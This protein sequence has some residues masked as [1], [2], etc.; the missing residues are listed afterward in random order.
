MFLSKQ[1]KGGIVYL[2]LIESSYDRET[3]TRRKKIVKSFGQYEVFAKEHPDE[4]KQL[5]EEYGSQ[6][7]KAQQVREKSISDFFHTG[8]QGASLAADIKCLVPQKIAHLLLRKIWD[9]ELLMSR[10]LRYLKTKDSNPVEFNVSN[11]ALY[12]S[13]L[14]LVNP[15]SY[16]RGLELSPRFLGDPM[17]DVSSDD[18]YRCLSYLSSHKEQLLK[19]I[20]TRLDALTKRKHSLIFYD[21]TNCYFETPYNDSYWYRKK[22]LR[23]IRRQ[24]RKLEKRYVAMSDRELNQVIENTPDYSM[25]VDELLE[26]MGEPFRMH[27]VSKEKRTDLPL[28][29]IALVIDENAIPIDFEVY[30]GNKS[31]KNTMVASIKALKEKYQIDNAVVVADNGLNSAA[32]LLM[33]NDENLGF[34]VAKSALSFEKKIREQELDL[35]TFKNM[36]TDEGEVTSYRYKIIDFKTRKAEFTDRNNQVQ[37]KSLDC[38][39]LITF[40]E[41][42]KERDLTNL[43]AMLV[44]A[45]DAVM[46]NKEITH[47][48]SGWKQFVETNT[49]EAEEENS[50]K[51]EDGKNN[52][53]KKKKKMIAVKLNEK[54][55]EKRRKCAGFAGVLF[56]EPPTEKTEYQPAFISS[57]YHKM[58]K[59]EECFRIMKKD[60][61]IRPMYLREENSI[62]GHVFLCVTALIMLR[63]LQRK[64]SENNI[65]LS[66]EKIKD[67]L[68]NEQL[69]MASR[70]ELAPLLFKSREL[71]MNNYL[72]VKDED[73]DKRVNK[74]LFGNKLMDVL[75]VP[76][77]KEVTTMDELRTVFKIK[78]LEVSAFQKEYMENLSTE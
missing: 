41:K 25:Q 67:L 48:F 2:Y 71:P 12:F 60:F 70:G 50:A 58:V 44:Q 63:L 65:P 75:G 8:E 49:V 76:E 74:F 53:P 68:R 61:E 66:V 7:K 19:H 55:I 31:E 23:I 57:M 78:T 38:R 15:C 6:N 62:K 17:S 45:Q 42:R 10:H 18:A 52:S 46:Q 34:S 24:L 30:A 28:V 39:L 11:L 32:N 47:K 22:A 14:K 51:D 3:H 40:S 72:K 20:N 77:I 54:L 36:V 35:S 37:K 69:I 43:E 73:E 27:G 56:K 33:L 9:D 21:C 64:F 29:S 26:A 13:M 5:E 4:L 59:I 16:L 1:K